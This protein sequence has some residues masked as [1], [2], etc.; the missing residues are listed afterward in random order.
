[1]RRGEIWWADLLAPS[2]SSPGYRRPVV[3]I[4]ADKFNESSI[5]TVVVATMTGNLARAHSLGNV[6]VP[7]SSS[8]LP[9]DSV[10]NVTQLATISKTELDQFVCVLESKQLGL[11]E[12]GLKLVLAL[13]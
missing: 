5:N 11:L 9:R 7:S 4:S 1:M 6:V 3:I 10:I 2:G 13:P 8:G 12:D